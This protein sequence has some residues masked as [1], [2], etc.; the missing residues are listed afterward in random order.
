MRISGAKKKKEVENINSSSGNY[1]R[2][3]VEKNRQAEPLDSFSQIEKVFVSI[4]YEIA[5]G[6][7][8]NLSRPF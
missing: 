5:L 7:P 1:Y 2:E 3:L 6:S 4:L 8:Q